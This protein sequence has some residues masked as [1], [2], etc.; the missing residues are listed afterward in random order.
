TLLA[1]EPGVGKS[2]LLLQA[3]V[4]MARRGERVLLVS[5]EESAV[6]VR[7]R[8]ERLGDLPAELWLA[9]ETSL[10]RLLGIVSELEPA[11]VVVDSVQTVADPE[12]GGSPGS[13]A[14]VRGCS[15]RLVAMAKSSGTSVVVS[16]HVTKDGAVAGPRVL[17]HLVDTVLTFEG[18]RHHALRLL[19]AVKHRFGSTGELGL[20]EMGETGLSGI[21]D[22]S[23]LFLSDRRVGVP[24][25]VV[26]PAMEGRR[27]LLVELQAL[28]SESRL[29]MARR[30]AQGLDGGRLALVLAVTERWLRVP[31][32]KLDVFA[33]AVGGVRVAEP[34]ADLALG[35]ALVSAVTQ[36]CIPADL[37]ALGEIGLAGEVRQV[38]Q[39][40]RRLAEAAR[41]GFTGAMVP[42]SAPEPP[43]GMRLVRVAGLAD[44]ACAVGLTG[45][46]PRLGKGGGAQG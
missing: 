40:E 14:Q 6:Q 11:A 17:E 22:P 18:E 36:R 41:L 46:P 5:A 32:A 1:G 23:T 27:P 7:Q 25:A 29:S 4:S 13:V 31:F 19:R 15:Q 9:S 43:P 3:L 24:G 28:V 37:V 45:G 16:G 30:S 12:I 21:A 8:A 26:L 35:L 33:S 38:A 2:T 34:A 44:A 20:F 39:T 42:L 10:P